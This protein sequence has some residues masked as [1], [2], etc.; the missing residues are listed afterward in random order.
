VVGIE[1]YSLLELSLEEFPVGA[2]A[3]VIVLQALK[4]LAVV[5]AVNG[6]KDLGSVAIEGLARSVGE[7]GLSG[8]G[9]VGSVQDS[10][11]VGDAELGR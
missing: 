8:D 9:S 3:V 10:G 7:G 6:L 11:G 5:G 4:P 2:E 1:D